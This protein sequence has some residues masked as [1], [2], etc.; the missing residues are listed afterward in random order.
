MDVIAAE[1]YLRRPYQSLRGSMKRVSVVS[2]ELGV[3]AL[4][5]RIS[6]S[7]GLLDSA[8]V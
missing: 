8:N 6:R 1:H 5:R 2:A 4:Q 3:G 7:F